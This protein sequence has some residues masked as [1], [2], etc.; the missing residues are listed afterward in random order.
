MSKRNTSFVLGFH[1]C[2]AKI[3]QDALNGTLSLTA[4]NKQ[5]DWLGSGVYFWESDPQRAREW[6]VQST[7]A[8]RIKAP[9]V[10]GAVIDLGNCLDLTQRESLTLLSETHKAVQALFRS[11]KKSLPKNL[12]SKSSSRGDKLLRYLDCLVINHLHST[13]KELKTVAQ[14]DTVRGLFVEGKPIYPGAR[15]YSHTHTQIAV[16]TPEMIHGLFRVQ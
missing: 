5:Y 12:D 10:I 3:G 16:R 13:I 1:G 7:N 4:S 11:K 9:F 14:F 8:G 2:D 15:L 6:A